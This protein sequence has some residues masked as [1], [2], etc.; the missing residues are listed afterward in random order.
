MAE[1]D[2]LLTKKG[3]GY[4]YLPGELNSFA[5]GEQQAIEYLA[6]DLE[7]T[8]SLKAKIIQNALPNR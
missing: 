6:S 7:F 1:K 5:H 2:G 8:N 4:Y 3:G